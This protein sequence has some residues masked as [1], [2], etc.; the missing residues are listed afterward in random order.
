[1]D[2]LFWAYTC[3]WILLFAYFIRLMFKQKQLSV[4]MDQL[5]RRLSEL[6]SKKTP[7]TH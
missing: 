3:V 2:F 7:N 6:S 5:S 4:Q 1:M